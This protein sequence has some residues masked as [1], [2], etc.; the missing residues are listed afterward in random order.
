MFH[1]ELLDEYEDFVKLLL[2]IFV[3]M[4]LEKCLKYGI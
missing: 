3:C 4:I 2:T 1:V